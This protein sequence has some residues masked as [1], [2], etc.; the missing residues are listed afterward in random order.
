[1]NKWIWLLLISV[2]LL[3]V[4]VSRV[5][6]EL[7]L[8]R[9]RIWLDGLKTWWAEMKERLTFR[10]GSPKEMEKELLEPVEIIS[11]ENI[12]QEIEGL[13]VV[14]EE[15]ESKIKQVAGVQTE[16]PMSSEK[17]S[18]AEIEQRVNEIS[19]QVQ[20]ISLKVEQEKERQAKL[21]E[22]E[23]QVNEIAEQVNIVSQQVYQLV[24]DSGNA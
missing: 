10:L 18:L 13:E 7:R 12:G 9:F 4:L 5:Q 19:E 6:P 11:P 17:L 22:I 8:D 1:M 3:I 15:T 2:L 24:G 16:T 20:T 14:R 23:R 21:L